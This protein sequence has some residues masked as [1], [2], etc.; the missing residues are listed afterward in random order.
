MMIQELYQKAMRFAG[1][2]HALQKVPGTEA[3]YLLHLSNVAMEVLMAYTEAQNFDLG[4]ALQAAALHDI[5]EDTDTEYEEVKML[6]GVRVADAVQALT[7]DHTLPTKAERMTNSL[8]RICA[9]EKEVGMVKLADRITNLQPPPPLWS[10]RKI[11]NYLKEAEN[12]AKVLNHH[13]PYL[14]ERLRER[15]ENYQC[16]ITE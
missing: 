14:Q 13:N 12:I 10:N 16:Y 15:I 7:K 11:K 1:E 2:R 4:F 5:I 3:N 6:F 9:L 8:A